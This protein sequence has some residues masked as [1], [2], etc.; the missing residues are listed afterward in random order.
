MPRKITLVRFEVHGLDTN[1]EDVID[2]IDVDTI[3]EAIEEARDISS[4]HGVIAVLIAR[5][6]IT[7]RSLAAM[8]AHAPL[9]MSTTLFAWKGDRA[10]VEG[11]MAMPVPASSESRSF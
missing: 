5:V 4:Y 1:G 11:W 7:Y 6:E 3:E 2:L 10:T 9:D 8:G